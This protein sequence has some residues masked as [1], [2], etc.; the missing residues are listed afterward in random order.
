[1]FGL[2]ADIAKVNR[3]KRDR[4]ADYFSN[5]ARLVEETNAQLEV[6]IY[7]YGSRAELEQL[8]NLMP[9]TL[10]GIINL[11]YSPRAFKTINMRPG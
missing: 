1:M 9:K 11:T 2:R 4:A 5:I 3:E 7:P 8:A 10:R 6:R